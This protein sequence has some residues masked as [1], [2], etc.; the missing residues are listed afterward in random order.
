MGELA[1]AGAD[2]LARFTLSGTREF[3]W[4]RDGFVAELQDRFASLRVQDRSTFENSVLLAR[5]G[6]EKGGA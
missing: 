1:R 2:V 5:I 6:T 4:D 3:N